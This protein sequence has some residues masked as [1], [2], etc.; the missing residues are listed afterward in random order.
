MDREVEDAECED[1]P[2]SS[3]SYDA[4]DDAGDDAPYEPSAKQQCGHRQARVPRPRVADWF[5]DRFTLP[6]FRALW[7]AELQITVTD[8]VAAE[9]AE[10]VE[11]A[12]PLAAPDWR[13]AGRALYKRLSPQRRAEAQRMLREEYPTAAVLERRDRQRQRAEARAAREAAQ[14][15]KDALRRGPPLDDEQ[16]NVVMCT[17]RMV[18]GT[19][20]QTPPSPPSAA[21]PAGRVSPVAP[22]SPPGSVAPVAGSVAEPTSELLV[23]AGPGAGKTTTLVRTIIDVLDAVP[24]ARILALTFN[25]AA[26]KVMLER[27]K[28]AGAPRIPKTKAFS[29]AGSGCAIMTFDKAASGIIARATGAAT[30]ANGSYDRCKEI[31]GELLRTRFRERMFDLLLVDEGQDVTGLEAGIIEGLTMR[32]GAASA[33]PL[34]VFGDPRQEVRVGAS[35]FSQRWVC[36]PA[37]ARLTIARNY[38]SVPAIVQALNDY[39]R[40]AFPKLHLEQIAVR[41]APL[42]AASEQSEQQPQP[43]VQIVQAHGSDST[44]TD[45]HMGQLVG[46][47]LA[48][49][50]PGESYAVVPCS[51]TAWRMETATLAAC[52]EVH[53]LRPDAPVVM[54]AADMTVPSEPGYHL[55]TAAK[56]KGTE[57]REVVVYGID[58]DYGTRVSDA[59][60]AKKIYVAVSRARDSLLIVT[61]VLDEQRIKQLMAP[62]ICSAAACGGASVVSDRKVRELTCSKLQPVPVTSATLAGH[63]NTGV[64]AVP[65]PDGDWLRVE[66]LEAPVLSDLD[67]GVFGGFLAEAHMAVAIGAMYADHP[68]GPPVAL[69]SADNIR[70]QP[71][72]R[73]GPHGLFPDE[74]GFVL[75]TGEPDAMAG[76]MDSLRQAATAAS[77]AAYAHSAIRF[78]IAAGRPWTVNESLADPLL[79]DM[80]ARQATDV[81][82]RL[83]DTLFTVDSWDPSLR[84]RFWTRCD[85][86]LDVCR[87]GCSLAQAGL[88]GPAAVMTGSPDLVWGGVVVEFKHCAEARP[89]HDH[90]LIAY[91]AALRLPA[92]VLLNT[93]TG[94]IRILRITDMDVARA[95]L[96]AR[97]RAVM[98]IT[99]VQAAGYLVQHAVSMPPL[100]AAATVIVVLDTEC[101]G[102]G[103]ITE[104]GAVAIRT[105]DW[106][107]WGTFEERPP[108]IGLLQGAWPADACERVSGLRWGTSDAALRAA[109]S[110]SV[111]K[112]FAAW[113]CSKTVSP[114]LYVHWA[115][116]ETRLLP[117]DALVMDAW[118]VYKAWLVQKSGRAAARN[119]T[120]LGAAVDRLFHGTLP[121]APHCA[122]EDAIATAAVLMAVVQRGG[123]L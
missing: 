36:A 26:E 81:A 56:I 1:L 69:L 76:Y 107:V 47:Y 42:Q 63:G 25:V 78:T 3:V 54:L 27:L 39:S 106:S 21:P 120:G 117:P 50:P 23:M 92:G 15:E 66:Q 91:M 44:Q 48:R 65:V 52:Q 38:R 119:C 75:H 55:A 101:D 20:D 89:E 64:A 114:P 80:L 111:K 102:A 94:E 31:A 88:T 123:A 11:A 59:E 82:E 24:G 28:H 13:V 73:D 29:G 104:I 4:G 61:R 16:A 96:V 12:E 118:P 51:L 122:L 90:Q 110:A 5:A 6:E 98:A 43:P 45:Q 77:D 60:L 62:L 19:Q 103:N 7:Q 33:T 108:S 53:E 58:R 79:N 100:L 83:R 67:A 32:C 10:A 105:T 87:R 34:L 85:T 49:A 41:N 14:A 9:A 68:D 115:G 57:K 121:F 112:L 2:C 116:S 93:R 8:P 109:E 86:E 17:I 97:A 84:P 30:A 95:A 71:A 74:R 46:Q 35:W 22:A 113:V 99:H 40:A 70:I 72:R 18:R 37:R